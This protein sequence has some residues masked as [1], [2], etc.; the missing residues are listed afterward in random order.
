MKYANSI[1]TVNIVD[2]HYG[3]DYTFDLDKNPGFKA[4]FG[5]TYYDSNKEMLIEPDYG[6]IIGRIKS[7]N[8][9]DGV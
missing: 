1:I 2:S 6:E 8:N 4:A 5:I 3:D 9:E 7:W